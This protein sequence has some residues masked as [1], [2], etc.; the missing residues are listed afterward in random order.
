MFSSRR[1]TLPLC[2]TYN[3]ARMPK[4][5]LTV[6]ETQLL[7]ESDF[8]RGA[9]EQVCARM[10]ALWKRKTFRMGEPL[11]SAQQPGNALYFILSGTVKIHVEQTNGG[12]DFIDISA[13]GDTIG[14]MSMVDQATRSA[15]V[16]AM[17]ETRVLWM[18]RAALE[19][20]LNHSPQLTQNIARIISN[21]LRHATARIQIMA[22]QDTSG[23]IAHQL[24]F[25]GRKYGKPT[26]SG[27]FLPMRLT[28]GDLA[29]LVGATRERVNRVIGMFKRADILGIDSANRITI[30]RPDELVKYMKQ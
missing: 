12:D 4:L 8:L 28:Q 23:R 26:A 3:P 1:L 2:K 15:T 25:F 22:T 16:T 29:D 20:E 24:L 10:N 13:A 19:S 17:E 9:S 11:M 5:V 30:Y 27:I 7:A 6:D 14:E 18:E 21:R